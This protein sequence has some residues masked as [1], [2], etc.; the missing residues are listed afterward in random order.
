MSMQLESND[1]QE[2]VNLSALSTDQLAQI[3]QE[4]EQ[5]DLPIIT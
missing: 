2:Q 3:K 5:V 4:F 1:K